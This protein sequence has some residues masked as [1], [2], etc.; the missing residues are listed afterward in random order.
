MLDQ[1]GNQAGQG[2]APDGDHVEFF[3]AGVRVAGAYRCAECAYG[4][5]VR[6]ALPA[7]PMCAGESWEAAPWGPFSRAGDRSTGTDS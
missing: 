5:T 2:T 1:A 7:C 4:V 6:G 3:A